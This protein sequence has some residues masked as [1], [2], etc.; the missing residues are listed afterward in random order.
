M[1]AGEDDSSFAR[2]NK[3]IKSQLAKKKNSLVLNDLIKL[4]YAMRRKDILENSYHVKVI[5][6]KYP[7]LKQPLQVLKVL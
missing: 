5:F 4:S 1:P 3:E 6:E 2:H 7:F